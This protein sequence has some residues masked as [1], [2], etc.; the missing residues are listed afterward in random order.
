MGPSLISLA[1][2]AAVMYVTPGPN[3]VML[4]SSGANHGVRATV[5]HMR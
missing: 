5:P 4:A 1:I 3:N 2:F